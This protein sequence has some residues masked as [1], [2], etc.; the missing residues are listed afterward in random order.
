MGKAAKANGRDKAPP[1]ICDMTH[2]L[3][4]HGWKDVLG[5]SGKWPLGSLGGL[6]L[7]TPEVTRLQGFLGS[8]GMEQLQMRHHPAHLQVQKGASISRDKGMRLSWDQRA[9][10]SP[11]LHCVLGAAEIMNP[12]T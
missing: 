4:G 12:H 6:G 5:Q 1:H 3:R 11:G 9:P 8:R 10:G 7:S 2:R